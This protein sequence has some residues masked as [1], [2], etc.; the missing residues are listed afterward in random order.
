MDAYAVEEV[1]NITPVV[2]TW[3]SYGWFRDES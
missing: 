2:R 1:F 3:A